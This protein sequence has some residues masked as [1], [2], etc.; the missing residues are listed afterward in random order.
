MRFTSVVTP[1][2]FEAL[3]RRVS[4]KRLAQEAEAAQ[5]V[6]S[7]PTSAEI[8]SSGSETDCFLP[9][10]NFL[11]PMRTPHRLLEFSS[12][13]SIISPFFRFRLFATVPGTGPAGTQRLPCWLAASGVGTKYAPTPLGFAAVRSPAH[14]LLRHAVAQHRWQARQ[15][16]C[17]S[18][19]PVPAARPNP[20]LKRSANG[21]SHWP[22]SAGPAA[23]FALAVQ[24][25]TPLSP[26]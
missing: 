24:R 26:A 25:A 19:L 21:M 20:S 4:E 13:H 9:P 2:Q 5:S 22:S 16:G 11:A 14:K 1:V 3:F 6:R 18:A 7:R 8:S 23:H 10:G 15:G 12:V 17:P